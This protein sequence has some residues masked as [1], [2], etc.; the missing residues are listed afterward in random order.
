M[1]STVP[2]QG[3]LDLASDTYTFLSALSLI[4]PST[5][6]YGMVN[7]TYNTAALRLTGKEYLNNGNGTR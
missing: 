7:V 5:Y 3:L 4:G 2:R 6:I 1:G